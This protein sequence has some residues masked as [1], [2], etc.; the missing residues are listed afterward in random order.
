MAAGFAR[1]LMATDFSPC[2]EAAWATAQRLARALGA[3]LTLLH[4]VSESGLLGGA[5]FAGGLAAEARSEAAKEAQGQLAAWAAA[6]SAS[7]LVARTDLRAGPPHEQ[8]VE[9][10]TAAGADLIVIG[11]HGGIRRAVLGS[12]A[13]RVIRL[14]PC[15]V[16]AVREPS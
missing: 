11:I 5:P 15:P 12:V 10:A 9:A 3:E 13:D 1:I 14:A 7:G 16:V 6:A 8:I 4:V 2:A